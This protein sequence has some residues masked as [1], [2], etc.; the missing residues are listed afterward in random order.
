MSETTQLPDLLPV[1]PEIF[2]SAGALVLLMIGAFGGKKISFLVNGMA[3]GLV[4]AAALFVLPY[5]AQHGTTFH[6]AFILDGF[7]F[8]MKQLVLIGSFFAIAMS[9]AYA[10]SQSFDRFEYP[11]LILL[12]TVGMML[13]LSANDMIA[14]YLGLELQSLSLYVVAAINRDSV[15]STE[16]GLKYFVL[17]ALS[18]GM[19]L[20]GISLVYGFTGH[21][22][23]PEIAAVLTKEGASIGLVFGLV[24]MLAG[25]AFKISAVPF[26]MWT[27]D[28]YEGAPTPVTAF[29]AAAPKVAAMGLLVRVVIDVFQPV[30]HDWQQIVVFVSIA[31]MV[32][33]AFAAI[34]QTNIK[35]LMAYSS[36]GHMGYA[37]VGLAS[38][39]EQGVMGVIVYM[40]AYLVM[41]LGAFACILSMRRKSGMVEEI[42]ELSGLWKSNLPMAILLACIM[43]SLAGL[44]PFIGFFAKWYVFSAAVEAGLYPLAIIG[45]VA[46]VVGAYY[47]LRIIKVMFFDE[48]AEKF[49]PMPVELRVVLGLSSIGVLF[50]FAGAPSF[51]P[52]AT[53]AAKSLF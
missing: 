25:L 38:G 37:L 41:T 30:A 33:G 4:A 12:A 9:W 46:S 20:Y 13:M 51:I 42:S 2:L 6:G 16:A 32:L 49:E 15:R 53:A 45:V 18:S 19:L 43:W 23:F 48:P 8:Y 14:L 17:G 35:R 26:H 7:A 50:F 22:G 34:G 39:T 31:S 10:K 47:Y 40:T 44:P 27:P 11:V 28:V 29:F 1:L 21:V 3:M 5:G 36:I 52:I 24:F